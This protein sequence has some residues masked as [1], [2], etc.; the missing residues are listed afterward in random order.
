MYR[1]RGPTVDLKG[2]LFGQEERKY[3]DS[4]ENI[5]KIY[6]KEDG[7]GGGGG[8]TRISRRNSEI[9]TGGRS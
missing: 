5:R 9:Y 7:G 8:F 6:Q 4:S 2:E 1:A 3:G